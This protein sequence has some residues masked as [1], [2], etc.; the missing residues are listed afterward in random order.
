VTPVNASER[1]L[2]A[3][4][5]HPKLQFPRSAHLLKRADFQRVY[6]QGQRHFGRHMTV[7][8]LDKGG[9]GDARIG[10]TVTRALG[11]SVQ[12]NRIRRRLREAARLHRAKL[13]GGV[14]V[15]INPKKSVAQL[16][17]ERLSEDVAAAFALVGGRTTRTRS[18]STAS[19]RSS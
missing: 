15:V 6:Q 10:F 13:C 4:T 2:S 17:F 5:E 8:F 14:D 12:R 9:E 7:F 3:S 16:R 18:V 1:K 19:E 11:G